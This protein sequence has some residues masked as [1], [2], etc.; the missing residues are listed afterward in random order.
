M[1]E[2]APGGVLFDSHGRRHDAIEDELQPS[3]YGY[4]FARTV[5]LSGRDTG[6]AHCEHK[7]L[8]QRVDGERQQQWPDVRDGVGYLAEGME[9]HPAKL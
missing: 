5:G 1:V 2:H 8:R 3:P 4:H 7:L 9:R 6:S